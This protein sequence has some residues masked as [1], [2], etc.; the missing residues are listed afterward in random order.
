MKWINDDFSDDCFFSHLDH[1][2]VATNKNDLVGY[3]LY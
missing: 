3:L 2:Y 1:I